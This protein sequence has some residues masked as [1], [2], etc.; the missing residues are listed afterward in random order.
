VNAVVE[1]RPRVPIAPLCAAL[2]VSRA[3]VHRRLRPRSPT[4]PRPT[5]ARA[6]GAG[7][8]QRI[9]D[10]LCSE[11]FVDR[12][13]AEVVHTL[14][15]E[16][17]YLASER[18]MYRVLAERA[19]VRERRNQLSHPRHTRPELVATAPNEVW[20]WDTTKL[21]TTV[22]WSYFYLYVALDLFSR[23]VVGWMIARHESAALA[24]VLIEESVT[25]HGVEPGTLVLHSDRGSPM[26]SKTLAQL[27]AD[28]EVARSFSRPHTSNDNPFSES[29]LRTAKYH[30]SFPGRFAS[31]DEALGWGRSFFPWYNDEHRHSGI[32]F[33][34]PADVHFG[35]ADAVLDRRHATR[36]A[37]YAEHPERFPHGPPKR[38]ELPPATYINP[39]ECG[40]EAGI[41][42]IEPAHD[43]AT[44]D[45]RP[46]GAATASPPARHPAPPA[47]EAH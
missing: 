40:S 2:G 34:T 30:P 11:R 12:S 25:K 4:P 33:L 28:L 5:P 29:Q 10:V 15:D 44:S 22:K 7:E 1:L 35:R 42:T 8:K 14:L 21:R 38:Q 26:T 31:I 45:P 6:L 20:S 41:A 43:R 24:K 19:E 13:P 46:A 18:T 32:A 47:A 39:P 9:V 17:E 37:A 16:D 36:L 3:T 23:Y 27:L